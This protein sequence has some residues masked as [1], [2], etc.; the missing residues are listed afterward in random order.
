MK[1]KSILEYALTGSLRHKP[2]SGYDLRKTFTTTGMRHYSDSPGSIYPALKRLEARGWIEAVPKRDE[3]G[4][5]RKRQLF[6]ITQ[7]GKEALVAWLNQPVT[8]DD[9]NLR[10]SELM[11]RFAFMDGNVPRTIT[12][13]FLRDFERERAVY[14]AESRGKLEEMR[15]KAGLHTGVLAYE[16]GIEGMEA[17]VAWARRARERLEQAMSEAPTKAER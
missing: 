9:V 13:Q 12:I 6:A 16:S 1:N 15:S 10:V 17:Q 5:P 8:R 2:Q 3:D 7:T 4:D 11:L 14:A